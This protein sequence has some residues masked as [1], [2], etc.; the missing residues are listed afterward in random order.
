[1]VAAL[2]AGGVGVTLSA[3]LLLKERLPKKPNYRNKYV[4]TAT[5]ITLVPAVLAGLVGPGGVY[6][7]YVLLCAGVG[8]ADDVWGRGERGFRGHLGAF[9]RGRVSTGFIKLA[10]LGGGALVVGFA[11][12]GIG[13]VG[14]AGG[15]LLAGCVNLANLLDVRPGRAIKFTGPFVVALA[16]TSAGGVLVQTSAVIGGL[17]GLFYFDLRG[18]IMLGDAGAAV[19]GGVLGALLLS[20]GPGVAWAV[21]GSVVAGLTGVAEVSSI[22]RLIGRVGLLNAYD[23]WGR[24]RLD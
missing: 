24:D 17:A 15:V 6:P 22:S 4:P 5:G 7:L 2:L 8:F 23:L 13:W 9:L 12:F 20:L 16:F 21:G 1:M 18:R 11:E 10:A 19:L 14:L 3:L